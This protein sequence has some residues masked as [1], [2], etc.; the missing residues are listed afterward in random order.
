M[1]TTDELGFEM[2]RR[3]VLFKSGTVMPDGSLLGYNANPNNAVNGNTPGETLIANI[4]IGTF[5]I[6]SD[7]TMWRKTHRSNNTWVQIGTGNS[8]GGGSISLPASADWQSTYTTV[9]ANSASW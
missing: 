4:S 8:S 3:V 7:G 2:E 9:S 1:P 5:Y 6:Q